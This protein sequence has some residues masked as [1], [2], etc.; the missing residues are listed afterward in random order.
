MGPFCGLLPLPFLAA[1]LPIF[2]WVPATAN[3]VLLQCV[4]LIPWRDQH[5]Q[6]P[7]PS[8]LFCFLCQQFF[9]FVPMKNLPLLPIYYT[10]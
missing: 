1:P 4:K 10:G 5:P 2:P 7:F 8:S 6:N 3:T 9:V